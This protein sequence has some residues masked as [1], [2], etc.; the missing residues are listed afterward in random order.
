MLLFL[1]KDKKRTSLILLHNQKCEKQHAAGP[2]QLVACVHWQH[3]RGARASVRVR[4]AAVLQ[5]DGIIFG[6]TIHLI[7]IFCILSDYSIQ[8]QNILL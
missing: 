3:Q 6:G 4:R 5:I 7:R 2:Q 8:M 1:K